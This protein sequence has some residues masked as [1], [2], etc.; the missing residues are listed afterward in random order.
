MT[1]YDVTEMSRSAADRSGLDVTPY[2]LI[3]KLIPPAIIVGIISE[4]CRSCHPHIS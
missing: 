2:A 1:I 3:T 4:T